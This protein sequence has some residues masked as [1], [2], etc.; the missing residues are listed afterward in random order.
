MIAALKLNVFDKKYHRSGYS[1]WLH[2][3]GE[4]TPELQEAFAREL[5]PVKPR[6]VSKI[7]AAAVT[8]AYNQDMPTGKFGWRET[9][10][11][12]C[13]AIGDG[14]NLIQAEI[15]APG[16]LKAELFACMLN[17]RLFQQTQFWR[18]L[19]NVGLD[20]ENVGDMVGMSIGVDDLGHRCC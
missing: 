17:T 11:D 16:G 15:M 1:G 20:R 14:N 9:D 7:D 6:G 12:R 3:R 2:D 19:M 4:T 5:G 13:A 8:S 18:D 10:D